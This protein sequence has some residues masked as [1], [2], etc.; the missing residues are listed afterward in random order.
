M[1]RPRLQS[2]TKIPTAGARTVRVTVQ[3]IALD[4]DDRDRSRYASL[5]DA[6]E[7]ARAARF[8]FDRDRRRFSTARGIL[9]EILGR[10]LEIAP[11]N[12]DF[13][14]GPHGKPAVQG[15]ALHFNLS[16]S[17][18]DGVVA[19]SRDLPVGVDIE[20]VR[21]RDDLLGLARRFF[22]RTETAA[23]EMAAPEAR[24]GAFYRCW[25]RK[26]AL[27]KATGAGIS[28][29]LSTFTVDVRSCAKCT[30]IADAEGDFQPQDWSL[31]DLGVAPSL[32]GCV[33]IRA[34]EAECVLEPHASLTRRA[35]AWPVSPA[36][37]GD[38]A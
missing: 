11:E 30:P 35:A 22:S 12:V 19:W 28:R 9:R 2:K 29:T 3:R 18:D 37:R 38:G 5:L 31:I 7:R 6:G 10:V 4:L 34:P 26:E 23:I 32:A 27:L 20:E 13:A 1:A 21:E 33:A 14:Y 24:L 15:S 36:A 8:V 25:T 17:G 16:H